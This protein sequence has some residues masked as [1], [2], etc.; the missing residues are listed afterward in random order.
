MYVSFSS[1]AV[2]FVLFFHLGNIPLSHFCLFV[3]FHILGKSAI[4]PDLENS[5]FTKK[6]SCGPIAQYPLF[7]R[8]RCF[9][10]VPY[11]GYMCP[12]IV[13]GPHL[14]PVQLAAIAHF[15]YC[16]QGLVP[17]LLKGQSRAAVG[18]QLGSISSQTRCLSSGCLQGL[19]IC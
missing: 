13:A 6:R 8:V 3:C 12:T 9:R 2:V 11:V 14:P 15:S 1:L 19:Q 4:S 16:G 5:G 10:N 17:M 18:L 7:I